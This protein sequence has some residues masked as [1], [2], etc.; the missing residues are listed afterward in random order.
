MTAKDEITFKTPDAL[1]NG[2]ATVDVIQ[3]CIPD[4]KDAWQA[5]SIDIDTMLV[6]IRMATYGQMLDMS[7]KIPGTEIQ[8]DWQ[9][10]LQNVLDSYYA[11]EFVD[12]FKIDGFTIQMKPVSYKTMTSQ[13]VKAFEEQRIFAIVNDNDTNPAE[14]LQ[15]FQQSFKNLTELN[16]SVI[17]DLSL[18]HI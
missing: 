15:K 12:T 5:P 1:L 14:K 18:I 11:Q 13:T 3:S 7:G 9:M 17:I 8:K 4:I 10:N 16:I 6:A 2:Q